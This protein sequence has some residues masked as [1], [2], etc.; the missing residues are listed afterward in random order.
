MRLLIESNKSLK[1]QI[2]ELKSKGKKEGQGKS[3]EEEKEEEKSPAID[4][5][6]STLEA[7]RDAFESEVNT[8]A[9]QNKNVKK[10]VKPGIDRAKLSNPKGFLIPTEIQAESERIKLK[11]PID[12]SIS[13][14]DLPRLAAL[15]GLDLGKLTSCLDRIDGL[16]REN[17]TTKEKSKRKTKET[18]ENEK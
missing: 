14:E 16:R 3:E 18:K 4:N 2:K 8:A 7:Y 11:L 1:K 6:K 9:I 15:A 5:E 10:R 17:K 12:A 13:K